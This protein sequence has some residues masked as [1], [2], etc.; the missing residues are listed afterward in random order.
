LTFG[1]GFG[2]ESLSVYVTDAANT[3][4]NPDIYTDAILEGDGQ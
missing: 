4:M 2:T 3:L 1:I